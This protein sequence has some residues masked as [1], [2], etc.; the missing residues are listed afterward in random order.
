MKNIPNIEFLSSNYYKLLINIASQVRNFL[1]LALLGLP[2]PQFRLFLDS[3]VW[4]FKHTMR[5]IG[6][7]GLTICLDLLTNVSKS[8]P[9]IANAFFQNYFISILQD[10]FFVLTSTSHKSGF[11]LQSMILMNMFQLVETGQITAPLYD[12]AQ[13]PQTLNN[14]AYVADFVTQMLVSAFP[15]LQLYHNDLMI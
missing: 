10:V 6:D 7:V 3:V 2:S 8:D 5:D 1:F 13:N 14:A 12:Q 15:H 9:A 11:K 4:A